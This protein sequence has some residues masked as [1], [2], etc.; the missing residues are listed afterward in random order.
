MATR[1]KTMELVEVFMFNFKCFKSIRVDDSYY[2]LL[3]VLCYVVHEC[4]INLVV[5]K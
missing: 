3:L 2:S 4:N 1:K 5:Q